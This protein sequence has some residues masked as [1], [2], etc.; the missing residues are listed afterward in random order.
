MNLCVRY[1][2]CEKRWSKYRLLLS[3][4]AYFLFQYYLLCSEANNSCEF[5][6]LN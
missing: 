5:I 3:F 1:C 6:I 2:M 4:F